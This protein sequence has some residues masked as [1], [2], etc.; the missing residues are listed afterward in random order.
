[1]EARKEDFYMN[2][3]KGLKLVMVGL[4]DILGSNYQP[5]MIAAR[6]GNSRGADLA[7]IIAAV[8]QTDLFKEVADDESLDELA[9]WGDEI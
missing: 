5:I 9:K 1:M 2:Q 6:D 8:K 3:E 7:L 4:V